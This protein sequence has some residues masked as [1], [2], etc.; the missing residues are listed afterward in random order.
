MPAPKLLSSLPLSSKC[1][2]G[3]TVGELRHELAPHRSAIQIVFPSLSMSTVLDDPHCLGLGSSPCVAPGV[4]A[5]GNAKKFS[6]VMSRIGRLFTACPLRYCWALT[7]QPSIAKVA[8][9]TPTVTASVKMMRRAYDMQ[10][11]P[12]KMPDCGRSL[13]QNRRRV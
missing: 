6:M 9:V 11:P 2:T 8:A 7:F 13:T 12:E 1:S 4:F 3:S 5:S 10:P